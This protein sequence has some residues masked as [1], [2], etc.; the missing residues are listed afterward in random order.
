MISPIA[1]SSIWPHQKRLADDWRLLSWGVRIDL[2][3]TRSHTAKF[4]ISWH[5]WSNRAFRSRQSIGKIQLLVESLL[6]YAFGLRW[7]PIACGVIHRT[8]LG[9]INRLSHAAGAQTFVEMPSVNVICGVIHH[10]AAPVLHNIGVT[11]CTI[12]EVLQTCRLLPKF[13][14]YTWFLRNLAIKASQTMEDI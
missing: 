9:T 6:N 11:T 4:S 12:T 13:K 10:I 3:V 8:G 2:F 14:R 5:T 7:E 1:M